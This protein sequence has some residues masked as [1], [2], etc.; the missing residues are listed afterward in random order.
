MKNR[1]LF[2]LLALVLTLSLALGACQPQTVEKV[3]EKTVEVEKVVEKTVLVESPGE[4]EVDY[5]SLL[6]GKSIA[7]VLSGPV[8]DAG[9]N[10]TAYLAIINLRDKYGMKIA[11][12]EDTKVEEAEQ[13]IREFVEAGYDIVFAHGYEYADQ[14]KKVALEYPDKAFVQSNGNNAE[15]IANFYTVGFSVGEG[16][17]FMGRTACAITKT[18]KIAYL[19]GTSFPVIDHHIVMTK[20]GCQDINKGD[21]QVL[22]S[23]VGAW[24]DPAKAKELGKALFEQDVDVI[25][26]IAD[27][28]DSGI[29]EAGKEAHDAGK[30]IK[31]ISWVKDKNY[32]APDLIIGGW[33]EKSTNMIDYAIR[34]I[35]DGDPGG[36][37]PLGLDEDAVGLNPFYGLVPPE[38]EEDV[39]TTLQKYMEDHTSVPTLIVRKDL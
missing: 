20:Q 21:V 23:Y 5:R 8:N 9:W 15:G 26:M 12:R 35:A 6:E 31:L 17:Y 36:H 27:A 39:V 24:N 4:E 33:E 37:F 1:S 32:M 19:V 2:V 38:V 22:E 14:I 30:D 13:V 3:V 7:A 10:T 34:R 16:G 28:G 18:G 29:V 11:Y 25:I